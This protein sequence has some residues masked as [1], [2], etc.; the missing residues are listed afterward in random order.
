[1]ETIVLSKFST[2]TCCVVDLFQVLVTATLSSHLGFD[3]MEKII[4]PHP[5][6]AHSYDSFRQDLRKICETEGVIA[7]GV[8]SRYTPHSFRLGGL[9]MMANGSVVPAFIQKAGRHKKME[10]MNLY[11]NPS[12][13]TALHTSDLLCGN[14]DSWNERL[15]GCKDSLDPF[16]HPSQVKESDDSSSASVQPSVRP[17]RPVRPLGPARRGRGRT[18]TAP[19][20]SRPVAGS[21]PP[22]DSVNTGSLD[23]DNVE[24]G[25]ITLNN[26]VLNGGISVSKVNT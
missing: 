1:M 22:T 21:S 15:V 19:P 26:L 8:D 4:L 6:V 10:S 12:I 16:L 13:S 25:I 11:M 23:G 14:K 9:S 20:R 17:P 18:V 7:S 24:N 3:L 5:V 2:L